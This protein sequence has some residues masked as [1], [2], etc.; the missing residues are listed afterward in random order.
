LIIGL[1]RQRTSCPRRWNWLRY[2]SDERHD[3][4]AHDADIFKRLLTGS[5][6]YARNVQLVL[7]D[8]KLAPIPSSSP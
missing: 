4:S 6:D 2:N 3:I 1:F 8:Q 5:D 7:Q